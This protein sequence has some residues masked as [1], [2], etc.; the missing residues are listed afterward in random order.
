M[1]DDLTTT[2]AAPAR[3][4]SRERAR[5]GHRRNVTIATIVTVALCATGGGIAFAATRTAPIEYR[6]TTAASGDVTQTV[7]LTGTVA[8]ASRSD[9]AFETAGT[10]GSVSVQLG[11]TVTAGETLATLQSTSLTAAITAAQQ[12][13]TSAQQTLAADLVTQA[14]GSSG[15]SS[16]SGTSGST[17]SGSSSGGSG[18]GTGG[19][20][21]SGT[22]TGAGTGTGSGSGSGSPTTPSAAVTKAIAAV[23]AAQ[24][25]LVAQYAVAQAALTA[26]HELVT[27]SDPTCAPFLAATLDDTTAGTPDST[28][29]SADKLAAAKAALA[30]CKTAIS[31]VLESEK[32]TDA[33]QKQVLS[34]AADLDTA[35][36]ALSAALAAPAAS[37]SASVSGSAAGTSVEL[38]AATI[39]GGA[40]G[41]SA[42][43]GGSSSGT[44][45]AATILADEAAITAANA[46]LAIAKH[47]KTFASLTSPIDGTVAAVSITKGSAVSAGSTSEVI[48][49]IGNDGFIVTSTASLTKAKTLAAGQAVSISV[50]GSS[51]RLAGTVS[52]V[53]V[54]NTS[55]TSTTPSY[56]VTVAVT[57][58]AAKLLNG[59]S[60]TMV[61]TADVAKSVLTVPTSA[62]HRSAQRYSITVLK[63]GTAVA[64]TVKIGA[65]GSAL[66]EITSGISAGAVIVL[67][68]VSST[69]I[70][71]SSSTSTSNGGLTG[72]SGSGNTGGG[73]GGPPAGF[74]RPGN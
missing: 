18:T 67:A 38:V 11:D 51:S 3:L 21:S 1:D 69:T 17:P 39:S 20:G 28:S 66:T 6:T 37:T 48:T 52:S 45:T 49:V 14:S 64:T 12:T 16:T 43:A 9:V 33:A 32:T 29:T 57:D 19:S 31:G 24:K 53:G 59:A 58:T 22:G 36:A 71:D 26:T 10:V 47:D 34:L 2:D 72:L 30:T 60:A 50:P 68:D 54:L 46:E 42:T 73:T 55:T 8:S 74:T 70:G 40:G 27:D 5:R 56:D 15:S 7:S 13:V 23:T 63:N 61:V 65:S 44:V 41:A 62:L 25:A 35:V 4:T